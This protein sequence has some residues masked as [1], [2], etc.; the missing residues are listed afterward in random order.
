MNKFKGIPANLKSYVCI[1]I[2][3]GTRPVLF[4]SREGGDWSFLCGDLHDDVVDNYR[5]VGIGH[6]FDRDPTLLELLDLPEEWDAER[7][8]VGGEWL[9]TKSQP[10]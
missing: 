7:Q 8:Y 10:N 1:H 3:N 6:I 5:V 4:V 9:R 2:F